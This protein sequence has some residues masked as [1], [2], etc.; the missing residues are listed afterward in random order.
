MV[1]IKSSVLSLGVPNGAAQVS[2]I[3]GI[4]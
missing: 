1:T 4:D 3:L 2:I